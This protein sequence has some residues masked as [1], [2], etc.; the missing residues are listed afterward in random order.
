MT[1]D[2]P[3]AEL[4]NVPLPL[5]TVHNPVPIVAVFPAKVALV[6]QTVWFG[7]ATATVGIVTPVIVTWLVDAGQG[8]F[9]IVH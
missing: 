8:G 9:D 4:V 5:M 1:A 7:P 3:E 2:V 6:P